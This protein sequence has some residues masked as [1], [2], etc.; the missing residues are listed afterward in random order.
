[1]W[2]VSTLTVIFTCDNPKY[3]YVINDPP[4]KIQF[5]LQKGWIND[6]YYYYY[7]YYYYLEIEKW[8][9]KIYV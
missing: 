6:Y 2:Y 9:K 7:Y 4:C 3:L 1:M 5:M 8:K